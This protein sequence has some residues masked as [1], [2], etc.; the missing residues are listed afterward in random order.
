MG[1]VITVAVALTGA[2]L[3][4]A[5]VGWLLPRNHTATCQAKFDVTPENLYAAAVALQASSSVKTRVTE[6][7]PPWRRVTE[8]LEE[9]GAAFGGTWTLIFESSGTQTKLTITEHGQV[10]NPL[11]RFLSRFTFGHRASIDSF[12]KALQVQLAQDSKG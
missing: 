7:Q 4:M 10:H 2:L 3:A 9:P 8:V 12:L 11:F 6:E 1:Y 5:G